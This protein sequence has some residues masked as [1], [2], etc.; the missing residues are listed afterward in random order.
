MAAD[1]PQADPAQSTAGTDETRWARVTN[2]VPG[3]LGTR[4]NRLTEVGADN[5]RTE[6]PDRQA[7]MPPT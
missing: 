3:G 5:V 7:E 2:G 6:T 1:H 4:S